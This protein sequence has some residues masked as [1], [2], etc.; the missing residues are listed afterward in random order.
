MHR[1]MK[2]TENPKIEQRL[3][4]VCKLYFPLQFGSVPWPGST[5]S[6][7]A[8]LASWLS[9]G[10]SI[11]VF[12]QKPVAQLQQNEWK[13]LLGGP[14]VPLPAQNPVVPWVSQPATRGLLPTCNSLTA[15]EARSWKEVWR[16]DK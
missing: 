10:I 7:D 15:E 14:F 2:G 4:N 9:Q 12:A 11:K 8:K 5:T 3:T 6:K 1:S 13:R 16:P